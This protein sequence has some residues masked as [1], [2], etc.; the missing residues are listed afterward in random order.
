MRQHAASPAPSTLSMT[1]DFAPPVKRITKTLDTGIKLGKRV[2][3]SAIS[4]SAANALQISLS[5]RDLQRSLERD[6]QLISNAY[7]QCVGS[8]GE[9]FTRTLVENGKQ[10][11]FDWG[12]QLMDSPQNRSRVGSKSSALVLMTKSTNV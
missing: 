12:G 5:A 2:S 9:P 4:A 3:K 7:K 1:G 11:R 8:Y 10:I 6:L